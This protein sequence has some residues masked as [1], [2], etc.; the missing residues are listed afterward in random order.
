LSFRPDLTDDRR[1]KHGTKHIKNGVS[2]SHGFLPA[3]LFVQFIVNDPALDDSFLRGAA[4]T[5]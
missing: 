1:S 2:A 3:L 4:A 5:R